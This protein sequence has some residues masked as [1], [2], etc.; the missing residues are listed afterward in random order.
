MGHRQEKVEQL[1]IEFQLE[2]EIDLTI[3]LPDIQ[4]KN[5]REFCL[6]T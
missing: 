4:P 5:L 1:N 2:I 6:F 3:S